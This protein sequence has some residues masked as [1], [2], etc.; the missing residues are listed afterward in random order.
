MVVCFQSIHGHSTLYTKVR[1]TFVKKFLCK[2][3]INNCSEKDDIICFIKCIWF[4]FLYYQFESFTYTSHFVVMTSV[5]FMLFYQRIIKN[6]LWQAYNSSFLCI[7]AE[8][9]LSWKYSTNFYFVFML[10][11]SHYHSMH[12][13][14]YVSITI[15]FLYWTTSWQLTMYRTEQIGDSSIYLTTG[16]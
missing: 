4:D 5:F 13:T 9:Y 11:F 14:E 6:F 1:C 16:P 3:Q 15:G 12:A 10:P 7:F 2:V 8:T